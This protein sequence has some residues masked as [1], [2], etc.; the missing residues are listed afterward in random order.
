MDMEGIKS[1]SAVIIHTEDE[2]YVGHLIGMDEYFLHTKVGYRWGELEQYMTEEGK[3]VLRKRI[4]KRSYRRL[5]LGTAVRLRTIPRL[6]ATKKDMIEFLTE[7]KAAAMVDKRKPVPGYVE[8]PQHVAMAI[9]LAEI[10]RLESFTDVH[11]SELLSSLD[12]EPELGEDDGI[13][14]V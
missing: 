2:R 9:P 12:F 3:Q 13:D 11:Q 8:F 5:W 4:E 14:K 10:H 6:S 1:G 7:W